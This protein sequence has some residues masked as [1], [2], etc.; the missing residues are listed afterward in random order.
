MSKMNTRR[1]PL[2]LL[3]T[4]EPRRSPAPKILVFVLV[5]G[6]AG[7]WWWGQKHRSASVPSV[8]ALTPAPAPLLPVAAP[9]VAPDPLKQSRVPKVSLTLHGPL[10]SAPVG[11]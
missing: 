11:S 10:Q 7:G 4:E 2:P 5:I 1:V 3:S 6:A 9:S 8:V